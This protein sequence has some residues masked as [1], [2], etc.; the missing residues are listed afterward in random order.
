MGTCKLDHK[1]SEQTRT[2]TR[3]LLAGLRL[4]HRE[5][6]GTE[7][8]PS[9]SQFHT[10]S[11]VVRPVRHGCLWIWAGQGLVTLYYIEAR[12][13]NY[14]RTSILHSTKQVLSSVTSPLFIKQ[15]RTFPFHLQFP[16]PRKKTCLSAPE[17]GGGVGGGDQP[18]E[19]DLSY[20]QTN[21]DHYHHYYPLP[22]P[23]QTQALLRQNGRLHCGMTSPA[24]NSTSG[25]HLLLNNHNY[26]CSHAHAGTKKHIQ[27]NVFTSFKKYF[28]EEPL[29][30]SPLKSRLIRSFEI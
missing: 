16:P 29:L 1:L 11:V 4:V 5:R 24:K 6:E 15:A 18:R 21:T 12:G 22:A 7:N 13:I 27:V 20:T 2:C 8:L 19:M 30:T 17:R 9:Q 23:G 3:T 25:Q 26:I 10:F 28:L 14:T